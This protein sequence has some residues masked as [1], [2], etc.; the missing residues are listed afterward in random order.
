MTDRVNHVTLKKKKFFFSFF[1]A[2]SLGVITMAD[3]AL[4]EKEV[5]RS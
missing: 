3:P 1:E 2:E 5:S 4:K